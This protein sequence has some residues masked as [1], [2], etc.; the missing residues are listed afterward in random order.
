MCGISLNT[1]PLIHKQVN[2]NDKIEPTTCRSPRDTIFK[3]KMI[4]TYSN[5]FE[6]ENGVMTTPK[7][8]SILSLIFA[9]LL[10]FHSGLPSAPVDRQL[11]R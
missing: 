10:I 4:Q 6:L 3:F 8:H 7:R 2:I 1:L 5:N 11:L 9:S